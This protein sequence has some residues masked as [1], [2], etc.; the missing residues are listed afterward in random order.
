MK[1]ETTSKDSAAPETAGSDEAA[2]LAQALRYH[3]YAEDVP[4]IAAAG[5]ERLDITKPGASC[6][7]ETFS[8]SHVIDGQEY[9]VLCSW[10]ILKPE[11]E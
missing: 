10:Y 3:K 9:T 2:I 8:Y 5:V 4:L 7:V 6:G 1:D 11:A